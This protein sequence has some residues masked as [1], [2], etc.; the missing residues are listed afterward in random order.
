MNERIKERNE[1]AKGIII[2]DP[3]ATVDIAYNTANGMMEKLYGKGWDGEPEEAPERY[4]VTPAPVTIEMEDGKP[5]GVR[6]RT[7]DV[8]F[9]LALQDLEGGDCYSFDSAQEKLK[10]LGLRTFN[11][12][13]ALAVAMYIEEINKAMEEVGGKPFEQ[14][15]YTTSELY[16]RVGCADYRAYDSWYFNGTCGCVGSSYRCYGDFRCRPCLA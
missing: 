8:D 14:D 7:L 13:E 9:T 1:I 12:K 3:N 16:R 10:E 5:K 6:V 4:T 2:H 15:W 11:K